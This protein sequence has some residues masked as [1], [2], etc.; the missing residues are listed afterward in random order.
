MGVD[1]AEDPLRVAEATD[2]YVGTPVVRAL[3]AEV[4]QLREEVGVIDAHEIV[5]ARDRFPAANT[6]QVDVKELARLQAQDRALN[7]PIL[8]LLHVAAT[9]ELL[10]DK[11]ANHEA[12]GYG[13]IKVGAIDALREAVRA[14][15]EAVRA[16]RETRGQL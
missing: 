7:T 13:H 16:M 14:M 6:V 5:D 4:R 2:G 15:R 12:L 11:A 9:A 1:E 3:A 10:A 8:N